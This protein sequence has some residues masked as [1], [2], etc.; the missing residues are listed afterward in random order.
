MRS[1]VRL[2]HAAELEGCQHERDRDTRAINVSRTRCGNRAWVK[3]CSVCYLSSE[4]FVAGVAVVL[5]S[6]SIYEN[7]TTVD[8]ERL[9]E[10]VKLR[11]SGREVQWDYE[12][13]RACSQFHP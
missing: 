13:T 5:H 3:Y 6:E 9:R 11:D 8:R 2:K 4:M 12:V 1:G 10:F 7:G